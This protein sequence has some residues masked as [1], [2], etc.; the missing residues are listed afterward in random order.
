MGPGSL[1]GRAAQVRGGAGSS[2]ECTLVLCCCTA[3][4]RTLL[5]SALLLLLEGVSPPTHH[6]LM[7]LLATCPLKIA[8]FLEQKYL[9]II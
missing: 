4:A 5:C 7:R 9:S 6:H 1:S 3:G 8:T 2:W